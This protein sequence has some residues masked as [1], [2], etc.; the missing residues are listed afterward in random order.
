MT[1]FRVLA[2][3]SSRGHD[4]VNVGFL[5]QSVGRRDVSEKV[6]C[7][8]EIFRLHRRVMVKYL[9]ACAR[10]V[11]FCGTQAASVPLYGMYLYSS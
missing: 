5:Q 7:V 10:H 3:P 11:T 2:S 8:Q 4:T 6:K 9:A 1:C